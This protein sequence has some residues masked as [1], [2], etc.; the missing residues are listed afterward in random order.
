MPIVDELYIVEVRYMVRV[1][2]L[3]LPVGPTVEVT[4]ESG[5]GTLDFTTDA[6]FTLVPADPD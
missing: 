6:E 1:D 5:Y 2:E 3:S 4:F